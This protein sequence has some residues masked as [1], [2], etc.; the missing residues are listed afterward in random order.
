MCYSQLVDWIIS[1]I[2]SI[3]DNF[4]MILVE[5]VQLFYYCLLIFLKGKLK[6]HFLKSLF[7]FIFQMPSLDTRALFPPFVL[8]I[9]CAFSWHDMHIH[10][11]TKDS[12]SVKRKLDSVVTS[13]TH[14]SLCMGT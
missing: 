12:C 4:W 1:V 8:S 9:V 2:Y 3:F 7:P 14:R 5:G 13:K 6:Q 11:A 10:N